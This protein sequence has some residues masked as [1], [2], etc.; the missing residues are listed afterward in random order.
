MRLGGGEKT[1][2]PALAAGSLECLVPRCQINRMAVVEFRLL[3]GRRI[4]CLRFRWRILPQWRGKDHQVDRLAVV[5]PV[6]RCARVSRRRFDGRQSG[7]GLSTGCRKYFSGNQTADGVDL[8]G[9]RL[10]PVQ[11]GVAGDGPRRQ[12]PDGGGQIGISDQRGVPQIAEAG[13]AAALL[14]Q[15]V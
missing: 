4:G 1:A 15:L 2:E 6:H 12:A 14:C 7:G 5:H 10:C 11:S 13:S 9:V 8:C 3:C